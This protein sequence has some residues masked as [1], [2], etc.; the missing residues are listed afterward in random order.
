MDSQYE[1]DFG[2]LM[3]VCPVCLEQIQANETK[4]P[5]CGCYDWESTFCSA[6]SELLEDVEQSSTDHLEYDGG[7]DQG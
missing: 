3:K 7:D 2:L 1:D 5:I 4:C 6:E